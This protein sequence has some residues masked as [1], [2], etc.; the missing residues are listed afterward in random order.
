MRRFGM[1]ICLLLAAVPAFASP[2]VD[3]YKQYLAELAKNDIPAADAAGEKALQLAEEAGD[4]KTIP[5]LA[6]N[7]AK[8]R[9]RYEPGMDALP[10]AARAVQL[11]GQSGGAL[12]V[13]K[14]RLLQAALE[15]RQSSDAKVVRNLKEAYEN[16]EK[17]GLEPGLASYVALEKLI[18][19]YSQEGNWIKAAESGEGLIKSY[20]AIDLL[21]KRLLASIHIATGM[22]YLRKRRDDSYEPAY[23]HFKDAEEVLSH[24]KYPNVPPEYYQGMAWASAAR[25]MMD[26]AGI[27]THR[28]PKLSYRDVYFQDEAPVHCP[29]VE[30]DTEPKPTFPATALARGYVG[31][32]VLIYDVKPD[33]RVENVRVGAEVPNDKFAKR[34][35]QALEKGQ[36]KHAAN[37]PQQCRQNREMTFSFTIRA[38]KSKGFSRLK[39][40]HLGGIPT[41]E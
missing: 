1:V 7:L 9:V 2:M 22:A 18:G 10:L 21:N 37:L 6:Y 33:G 24:M 11:A 5:V 19:D 14:A 28:I 34:A 20:E 38:R 36:V 26:V 13:V 3:A 17:A 16:Y 29:K 12:P 32:A 41:K 25:S 35:V 40:R 30:W 31:S 15:R 27:R 39:K 23:N 8:L 4:A